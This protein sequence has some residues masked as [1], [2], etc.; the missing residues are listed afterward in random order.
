MIGKIFP[1]GFW[2]T[3][4]N[5]NQTSSVHPWANPVRSPFSS[6]CG[7]KHGARGGRRHGG[8]LAGGASRVQKRPPKRLSGVFWVRR[9]LPKHPIKTT[10]CLRHPLDPCFAPRAPSARENPYLIS[11]RGNFFK[12]RRPPGGGWG[13]GR[14]ARVGRKSGAAGSRTSGSGA[15]VV[16][17]LQRHFRGC[18]ILPRPCAWRAGGK[19]RQ[20][21]QLGTTLSRCAAQPGGGWGRGRPARGRKSEKRGKRPM[22][23]EISC[24]VARLEAAPPEVMRWLWK[25][26][27]ATS[28]GAASCPRAWR[29][30]GKRK[31]P[32]RGA[33]GH[34]RPLLGF[35]RLFAEA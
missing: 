29:A 5:A 6:A 7:A 1:G 22:F 11:I 9:P 3:K 19:Q 23:S 25:N 14:P 34:R 28:G 15:M 17:K 27:N 4:K 30:G 35:S 18:G 21:G 13:R 8:F 31:S 33:G 32:G 12:V 16:E 20:L 24:P 10:P 2:A 26:F